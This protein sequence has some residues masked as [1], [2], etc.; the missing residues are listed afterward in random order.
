MKVLGKI[1]DELKALG[2]DGLKTIASTPKDM[3]KSVAHQIGFEREKNPAKPPSNQPEAGHTENNNDFLQALYGASEKPKKVLSSEEQKAEDALQKEL[4]GKSPEEQ[5]EI[6]KKRQELRQMHTE[7]YYQPLI[8]DIQ[9]A[10]TKQEDV[11]T[12]VERV[13]RLEQQD[14]QEKQKKEEKK[15]PIAVDMA[16][17]ATEAHRGS[18]G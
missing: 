3:A 18:T 13:E 14:L 5:Q 10:G 8:Q 11:E 15:K 1:G 7:S 4:E 2:Q 12:K 9:R 16:E 17:R 6:M